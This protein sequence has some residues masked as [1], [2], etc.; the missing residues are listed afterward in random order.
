M[1]VGEKERERKRMLSVG[2]S[3]D[4]TI[5]DFSLLLGVVVEKKNADALSFNERDERAIGEYVR[6]YVH[7]RELN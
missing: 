5:H 2:Q 4:E 1:N 7:P 6:M 3:Q